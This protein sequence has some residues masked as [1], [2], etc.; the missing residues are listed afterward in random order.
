MQHQKWGEILLLISD[1][2]IIGNKSK[3]K[4]APTIAITPLAYLE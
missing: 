3:I 4:I 1:V 2:L